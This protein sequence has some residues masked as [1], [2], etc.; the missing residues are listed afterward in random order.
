MPGLRAVG[1]VVQADLQAA[2]RGEGLP[3]TQVR[4]PVED[5]GAPRVR[6]MDADS[7]C[8]A[9][10]MVLVTVV[11]VLVRVS[12]AGTTRTCQSAVPRRMPAEALNLPD[13]ADTADRFRTGR[14]RS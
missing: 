8:L 14:Y 10:V 9:S 3:V 5:I 6:S 7:K 12:V 2:E 13:V 4:D 1:S 11:L